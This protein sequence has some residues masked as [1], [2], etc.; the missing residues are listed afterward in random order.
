MTK[1]VLLSVGGLQNYGEEY[2]GKGAPIE[3]ITPA[4]YYFKNGKHYVLFDEVS[5]ESSEVTKSTISF[6]PDYLSITRRGEIG[7][8]MVIESDKKNTTYYT[9]PFGNLPVAI[10]G[11]GVRV[12]ET[13]DLIEVSA[14]YGLDINYAK[15]AECEINI[16]IKSKEGGAFS[17]A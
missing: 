7:A 5:E 2:G 17:L 10:D 8:H 12:K 15:A 4:T 3:V 14:A 1:D 11:Y 6:Y 9:T 16:Q 13:K